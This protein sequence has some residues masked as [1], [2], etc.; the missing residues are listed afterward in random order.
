MSKE[1][2]EK[3]KE[4]LI[5]M[6]SDLIEKFPH[7][8]DKTQF[9]FEEG[10]NYIKLVREQSYDQNIDDIHIS[11]LGFIVK[12][13]PKGIDNKTN[14]PFKIG[15]MLMAASWSKPATNFA[16]GNILDGYNAEKVRYTGIF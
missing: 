2:I 9:V 11:V 13:V 15:D 12:K 4:L 8:S 10:R 16:R 7:Q 1:L 3:T 5:Q 6:K 14:E